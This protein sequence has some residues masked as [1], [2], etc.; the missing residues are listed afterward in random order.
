[1]EGGREEGRKEGR[2][3]KEAMKEEFSSHETHKSNISDNQ[4]IFKE[5]FVFSPERQFNSR[6]F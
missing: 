2:K 6:R 3:E 1:M 5:N 4:G